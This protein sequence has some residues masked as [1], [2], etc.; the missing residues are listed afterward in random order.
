[1]VLAVSCFSAQ[2]G[3]ATGELSA[4][5]LKRFISEPPVIVEM[6]AQVCNRKND[7]NEDFT[8]YYAL[9]RYQSNGFFYREAP[10]LLDL[11]STN[12]F[13][14]YRVAGYYGDE[15]WSLSFDGATLE[16]STNREISMVQT[17][18]H[19]FSKASPLLHLGIFG[20]LPGNIDWS[21]NAIRPFTNFSGVLVQ[22]E[23]RV[24]PEGEVKGLALAT[25]YKGNRVP[26]E[27][28][29]E[30]SV[31]KSLPKYIPSKIRAWA[32]REGRRL[33]FEINL[34]TVLLA[35]KPQVKERFTP[36]TFSEH[37]LY[38]VLSTPKGKFVRSK[39]DTSFVPISSG[40]AALDAK[41]GM[42]IF[43]VMNVL[44]ISAVLALIWRRAA[45]KNQNSK[46]ERSIEA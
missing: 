15:Y 38:T 43:L 39:L 37:A 19:V 24:S 3:G 30:F 16:F 46:T 25:N 26:W 13:P 7:T 29:Y 6:I 36:Q 2:C 21:T 28:D 11:S 14:G 12:I 8:C 1:M 27:I 42:R 20:T 18:E 4:D 34:L 17:L 31:N 33:K 44:L 23:L 5:E 32:L 41:W 9:L 10:D 40:S 22:G 35:D 45:G